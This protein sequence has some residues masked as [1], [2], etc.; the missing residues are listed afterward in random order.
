MSGPASSR[1]PSSAKASSGGIGLLAV[2][3]VVFGISVTVGNSIG[4]GILRTPG[5]VAEQLPT[6]FWFLAVWILG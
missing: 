5:V 1:D 3:G 2:L 4:S 6:P